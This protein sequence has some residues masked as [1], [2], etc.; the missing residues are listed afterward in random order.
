MSREIDDSHETGDLRMSLLQ[1]T[2][3]SSYTPPE[4][5]LG[6]TKYSSAVDVWSLGCLLVEVITGRPMLEKIKE[7]S[8]GEAAYLPFTLRL[9]GIPTAKEIKRSGIPSRYH[10][11]LHEAIDTV[12]KDQ[13]VFSDLSEVVPEA[14]SLELDLLRQIFQFRPSARITAA[15]IVKH[16]ESRSQEEHQTDSHSFPFFHMEEKSLK[17]TSREDVSSQ[18][19]QFIESLHTGEECKEETFSIPSN[20]VDMSV[21]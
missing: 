6:A 8:N 13:S 5:L 21:H 7:L 19:E 3:R 1:Y 10:N 17:N 18:M 4:G 14:S 9:T 11:A 2:T 16:L 15:A 20:A 12:E